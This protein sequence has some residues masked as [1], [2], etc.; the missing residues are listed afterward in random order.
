MDDLY[1][2][3]ATNQAQIQ[4]DNDHVV[5]SDQAIAN[6]FNEKLR[7]YN[8]TRRNVMQTRKDFVSFQK[9]TL[10]KMGLSGSAL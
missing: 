3:T 7:Q 10:R 1:Y 5:T 6:T 8:S 4:L 9:D 2:F